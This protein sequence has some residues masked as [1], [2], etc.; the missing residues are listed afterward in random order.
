[1]QKY[2]WRQT[3][4]HLKMDKSMQVNGMGESTREAYLRSLRLADR[5]ERQ[6]VNP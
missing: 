1:M 3:E 4:W 2:W 5:L 6:L